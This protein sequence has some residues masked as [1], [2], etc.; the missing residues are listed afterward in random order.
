MY[1]K[2]KLLQNNIL[3]K[4]IK[5]AETRS[6]RSRIISLKDRTLSLC[7]PPPDING[8]KTILASDFHLIDFPFLSTA[9]AE[10]IGRAA[11]WLALSGIGRICW[12]TSGSSA[13]ISDR[14]TVYIHEPASDPRVWNLIIGTGKSQMCECVYVHEMSERRF[15]SNVQ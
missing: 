6:K 4:P 10:V 13:A 7:K 1:E 11:D 5:Y 8:G 14:L 2:F 3:V 15:F 12:P 9:R